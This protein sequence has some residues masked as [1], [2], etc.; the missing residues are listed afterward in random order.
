MDHA[1]CCSRG[2]Y[3]TTHHNEVQNLFGQL[4]T[5]LCSKV[6]IEPLLRAL[7]SVSMLKLQSPWKALASN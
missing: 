1:L 4:V 7:A 6:A 2:G 3:F 5:D